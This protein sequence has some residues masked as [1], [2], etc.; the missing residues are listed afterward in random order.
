MRCNFR[1]SLKSKAPLN[2]K[3][4]HTWSPHLWPGDV[5][6]SV[7]LWIFCVRIIGLGFLQM[8]ISPFLHETLQKGFLLSAAKNNTNSE[9]S[10]VFLPWLALIL[11]SHRLPTFVHRIQEKTSSN[12]LTTSSCHLPFYFSCFIHLFYK[13]FFNKCFIALKLDKAVHIRVIGL[14]QTF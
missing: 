6:R 3:G 4:K 2:V 13:A 1:K 12:R 14:L 7:S 9:E 10:I 8:Q 5:A 11:C